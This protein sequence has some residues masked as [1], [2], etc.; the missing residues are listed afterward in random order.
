MQRGGKLVF[1]GWQIKQQCQHSMLSSS[2]PMVLSC[3]VLIRC[4]AA[5]RFTWTR[6]N[7]LNYHSIEIKQLS[8]G[9]R[10]DRGGHVYSTLRGTVRWE[11]CV[12]W[13]LVRG[14]NRRDVVG[15]FRCDVVG[16]VVGV[17]WLVQISSNPSFSTIRILHR[18]GKSCAQM[19]KNHNRKICQKN[20]KNVFF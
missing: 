6:T 5:N 13:S 8:S 10:L 18:L 15:V 12:E 7:S 20:Q 17:F 9:S 4:Q 16:D 14:V 11:G 2:E 3:I 19:C 1:P